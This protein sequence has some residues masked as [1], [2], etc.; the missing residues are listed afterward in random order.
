MDIF[1][2]QMQIYWFFWPSSPLLHFILRNFLLTKAVILFIATKCFASSVCFHELWSLSYRSLCTYQFALQLHKTASSATRDCV[3]LCTSVDI[4][5]KDEQQRNTLMSLVWTN[6]AEVY[7]LELS[8]PHDVDPTF[9]ATMALHLYRDRGLTIT[10]TVALPLQRP[11]PDNH[12]DSGPTFTE[13]VAWQSQ[14][15]LL[16]QC[17]VHIMLAIPSQCQP[18]FHSETYLHSE[19]CWE[20]CESKKR[21]AHEMSALPSQLALLSQCLVH[22]MLTLPSQWHLPSQWDLWGNLWKYKAS[23]PRD[24]G[25][26]FTVRPVSQQTEK[27]VSTSGRL[28]F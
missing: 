15:A 2:A 8:C 21:L 9:T 5:Q 13:T 14:L 19:T 4:D 18:Y 24:V 22:I 16:P 20:I 26:T 28:C 10:V 12:S 1:S 27:S 25:L 23:C 3:M 17:L 6:L 11:W 7:V